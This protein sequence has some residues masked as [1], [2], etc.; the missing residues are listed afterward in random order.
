MMSQNT[1]AQGDSGFNAGVAQYKNRNYIAAIKSFESELKKGDAKPEVYTYLG[2]SYYAIGDRIR[3]LGQD[4]FGRSQF[5]VDS[6]KQ[7]IRFSRQ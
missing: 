3:A 6:E 4:F 5:V 7:V 1:F 2:H